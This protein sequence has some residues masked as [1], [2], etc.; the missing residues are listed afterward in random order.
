M[1]HRHPSV[2]T[3][4]FFATSLGTLASLAVCLACSGSS[5][6]KDTGGIGGRSNGG[7][8]GAVT[9]G[10]SNPG[11]GDSSTD[12]GGVTGASTSAKSSTGG[13]VPGT[14]G[15]SSVPATGGTSSIG[16][17]GTS[18]A[19]GGSTSGRG[20]ASPASGGTSSVN[21]GKIRWVG[22][23]VPID[24]NS[25]KFAWQ[26]AGLIANVSGSTISVKLR[27]EGGNT[28]YFQPIID[29]QV[30]AR[31]NV[32]SGADITVT[33]GTG[34]GSGDH[35]VELYRETEGTEGINTFLGF[36]AGT[37]T[38][39]PASDGRLLEVVGDSI[40]AGYGDLGNEPHPNGVANPACHWTAQNSSWYATYGAVAGHDLGAE[41]STIA[42]SGWGMY[43][44]NTNDTNNV[45]PRVYPN[46][47][48]T[49]DTTKWDFTPKAS[50]VVINL[51]TN[52]WANNY[53]TPQDPGIPYETAYVNFIATI[54]SHYPDAWI[55]LV[56]GSLLD[57]PQ[58]TQVKTRLSNVIAKVQASTNDT[59]LATFDLGVEDTSV[60]TGCDWHPNVA[61]QKRMAGILQAQLTAKLGWQ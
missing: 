35:L 41:V 20:G 51:G 59:K 24:A 14:G 25:A 52:D 54:R 1:R 31:F 40:S 28:V 3:P 5:G 47:L 18:A 23:V 57:D 15:T 53:T 11:A 58:L 44:D 56:I 55:F 9:G 2:R 61:E 37:V 49:T 19:V 45:L 16:I 27:T 50:V 42:L 10:V 12:T 26:G 8:S 17:G 33:L 13:S 39:A 36:T 29:H 32:D 6:N 46:A 21:D 30:L 43:R 22:R 34:L 7:A 60:P 48:G 4:S 38:G